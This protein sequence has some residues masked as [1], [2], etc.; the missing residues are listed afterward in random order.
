[1][2]ME[3]VRTVSFTQK[4]AEQS[5]L[6][7]LSNAL[8]Q[9][10]RIQMISK[11]PSGE[12]QIQLNVG[13]QTLDLKVDTQSAA[14]MKPGTLVL[15]HTIQTQQG[16]R[17][18]ISLLPPDQT[19]QTQMAATKGNATSP[20]TGSPNAQPNPIP[21]VG[22]EPAVLPRP[23]IPAQT[24]NTPVTPQAPYGAS[25]S[26]PTPAAPAAQPQQAPGNTQ[27]QESLVALQR[28]ALSQQ[29]S[30]ADLF[31]NLTAFIQ[32]V[33]TGQRPKVSPDIETAM[34]WLL[35][36][37]LTPK[38]P[39]E[40]AKAKTALKDIMT[41]LGL[42]GQLSTGQGAEKLNTNLK[43][44]LYLLQ[45]LLPKD[46]NPPPPP[47]SGAQRDHPPLPNIP[48][49][50]QSP[51]PPNISPAD[52]NGLA[53]ARIKSDVDA[54][55]ARLTLNQIASA[56]SAFS[57]GAS[58][59]SHS[60]QTLHVEIPVMLA[61]GTA[62]VQM[63]LE[64]EPEAPDNEEHEQDDSDADKKRR[65]GW[66]VQFAMNADAIGPVDASLRLHQQSVL[67]TL[68]AEQD[69]TV[70]LFEQAAPTLQAML[71][72]EGLALEGLSFSRKKDAETAPAEADSPPHHARL[73][74]KL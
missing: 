27:P 54:A 49:Q 46:A 66:T 30:L 10:A 15:L 19:E 8:P 64:H 60:M 32:Q 31:A 74:R 6:K 41:S 61:N 56:R 14:Q 25:P 43:A 65:G 29:R 18:A 50:G 21:K 36:F 9:Q 53:L 55:L 44:S 59:G 28:Q 24:G 4:N 42:L 13:G 45:A 73:D 5:L 58:A 71:E 39:P 72:E 68:A 2:A 35:G 57:S 51:R 70:A 16:P 11:R 23:L 33:E 67:I 3:I 1:M 38:Q 48:L 22:A 63:T 69:Q 37:Q 47:A 7:L 40:A 26:N 20:P 12:T 17:L 34:R 52:P 62:I